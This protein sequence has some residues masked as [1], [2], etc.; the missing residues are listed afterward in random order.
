[1]LSGRMSISLTVIPWNTVSDGEGIGYP[2]HLSDANDNHSMFG[3]GDFQDV[4]G[5]ASAVNWDGN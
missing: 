3:R 2:V 4:S 5:G 1:M